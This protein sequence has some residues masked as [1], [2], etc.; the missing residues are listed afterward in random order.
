MATTVPA[1]PPPAMMK[2]NDVD[3]NV[4]ASRTAADANVALSAREM[5]LDERRIAG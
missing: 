4:A 1:V 3:A 5:N 2:S